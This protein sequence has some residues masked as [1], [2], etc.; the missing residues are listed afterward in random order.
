MAMRSTLANGR[1]LRHEF[2][3]GTGVPAFTLIE[4]LVVIA[5]IAILAAMLLPA[6]NRAKTQA[7]SAR[8]KN[9]LHQ[10]GLALQLYLGENN[11][12][13]PPYSYGLPMSPGHTPNQNADYEAYWE[14][15]L[16]P[17]YVRNWAT[18]TAYQCPAYKS[19]NA[20]LSWY[21]FYGSYAYNRDGTDNGMGQTYVGG[22]GLG[23]RPS[24][25]EARVQAPSQM[26]AIGDSRIQHITGG[27]DVNGQ[28][29]PDLDVIAGRDI[30]FPGTSPLFE[31]PIFPARHGNNFNVSFCDAHVESCNAAILFS[32]SHSA[33]LWNSDH[34]PHP[35]TW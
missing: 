29:I 3:D 27:A 30:L 20:R 15:A 19:L 31:S 25:S 10:M 5:I 28:R 6:L 11:H 24:T 17:Y 9:H 16:E 33:A 2:R 26:I 32:F 1:P 12:F 21:G 4:L 7:D 34:Q 22:L 13:Y 18:N 14:N 8:C 23:W 35:E